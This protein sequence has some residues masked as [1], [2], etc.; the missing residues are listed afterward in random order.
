MAGA[1]VSLFKY[2]FPFGDSGF[3]ERPTWK[4][5]ISSSGLVTAPFREASYRPQMLRSNQSAQL[6]NT[7]EK[8][9]REGEQRLLPR[10]PGF[11][12]SQT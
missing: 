7:A 5:D 3:A 6:D 12:L 10:C 8:L 1:N 4:Y 9:W 2:R 11:H